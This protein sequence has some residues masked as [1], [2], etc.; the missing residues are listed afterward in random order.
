VVEPIAS[1]PLVACLRNDDPLAEKTEIGLQELAPR[2]TVLRDPD[3]HPAAHAR[4]LEMLA[5]ANS[6][7]HVSCTAA[8][9][10]DMT[11]NFSCATATESR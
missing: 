7:V 1:T 2:L 4:L 5:E 8:T 6:N 9:P 3:G 11:F 10:H